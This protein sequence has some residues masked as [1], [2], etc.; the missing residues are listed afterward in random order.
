MTE[1]SELWQLG[2]IISVSEQKAGTSGTCGLHRGT[3][4]D[5]GSQCL[6]ER[7]CTTRSYPSHPMARLVLSWRSMPDG[8]GFYCRIALLAKGQPL[9]RRLWRLL[10]WIGGA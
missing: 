1:L 10:L 8:K 3:V 7:F 5:H 4:T 6:Q 2:R 9:S